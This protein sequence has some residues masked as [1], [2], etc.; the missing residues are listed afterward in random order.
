MC[1]APSIR[2]LFKTRLRT[3]QRS[4][5]SSQIRE[6]RD[7]GPALVLKLYVLMFIVWIFDSKMDGG[8]PSKAAPP[9]GRD[10]LALIRDSWYLQGK[11]FW[12]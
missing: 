12:G 3:P 11:K 1:N 2:K 7:E 9:D 5:S 4:S 10:Q 6:V 8:I